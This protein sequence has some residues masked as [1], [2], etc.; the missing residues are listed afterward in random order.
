MKSDEDIKESKKCTTCG[1]EKNLNEFFN[2]KIY[3]DGKS[4][5]CKSCDNIARN[6]Y[7]A[8]HRDKHL[9]WQRERNWKHCYG[10]GRPEF[11][12]MWENQDGM[13]AICGVKMTNIEIDN[14]PVNKSNTS[15][16]DHCHS[17]GRVRGI[18]CARCNKG[19]GMFDDDPVK[20]TKAVD[21]LL[22][23]S[24]IH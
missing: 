6:A 14:D 12:A 19:L 15:C 20:I 8:K 1:V 16:I 23:N 22:R 2:S 9:R 7:R 24:Q 21:Y 3:K 18:L 4:Y 10:I 17:S 13:C 11:E 5:R